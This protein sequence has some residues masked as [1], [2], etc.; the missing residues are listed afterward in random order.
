MRRR[1]FT[2]IELLVVIAIIAV[3]IG[4]LLP[5]VQAAREAARRAQC[6]NNLKQIT[7]ALHNYHDTVGSFPPG[8]MT[9]PNWG[10]ASTWWSWASFILPQIENVPLYNSINYAHD[11]AHAANLSTVYQG[12]VTSF[13][14]PSDDSFKV[15][16]DRYWAS[17]TL[18]TT[19]VS[20]APSN[21]VGCW[22][23]H[24]MDT[25][26][27]YLSGEPGGPNYGC[28]NTFRGMLGQCSN[29]AVAGIRDTTDGTSNTMFIG[30]NSPN[31]CGALVWANGDAMLATTIIPLNWLTNYKDGQREPNGDL[32]DR[33]KTYTNSSFH[34]YRNQAFNLAFKSKHPGGCNVSFV[35]G[36]VK[37]LKQTINNRVYIALGTRAQGEVVSADQF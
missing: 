33:T 36:S 17:G 24:K 18:L 22:G 25:P 9:D 20:G 16:N 13:L 29:G 37:F 31:Y 34:C 11:I 12:L 3:L 21:Y 1:G 8:G 15:F 28:K 30:E 14:C 7:L 5:A 6:V 19:V 35:D 26:F 2:L 4:L 32:C 23:D 27:D 10:P